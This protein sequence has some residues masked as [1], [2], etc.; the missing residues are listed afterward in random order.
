[1]NFGGRNVGVRSPTLF[2]APSSSQY[3]GRIAPTDSNSPLDPSPQA[4]RPNRTLGHLPGIDA[5]RAIAVMAVLAYH[6][7]LPGFRG[8]FLGVDAFFV[9]SGF[10]IS[11]LICLEMERTGTLD[12][13][14]FWI[15]RFKRLLPAMY[16]LLAVVLLVLAF[17]DHSKLISQR[18]DVA[19]AASYVTNWYQ[20]VANQSYFEAFGRPPLLRHL[21]SLAVEEQFYLV[22][23]LFFLALQKLRA[24]WWFSVGLAS[25]AAIELSGWMAVL[26]NHLG[27]FP[28]QEGI[29]KIYLRTDTR[30]P[31]LLV[32]V[33]LGVFFTRP[34]RATDSR[35]LT[36]PTRS[37]PY[38]ELS[39][40][41]IGI[42]LFALVA[43][44]NDVSPWL[45]RGGFLAFSVL[46]GLLVLL[47]S[48]PERKLLRKESYVHILPKSIQHWTPMQWVGKRS[49]SLYLWHWPIFVY[50]RPGEDLRLNRWIVEILRFGLSLLAAEASYRFIEGPFR[51]PAPF[52]QRYVFEGA[53]TFGTLALVLFGA[54]FLLKPQATELE[55][56][57]RANRALIGQGGQAQAET[58]A[59]QPPTTLV[60][61]PTTRA[62]PLSAPVFGATTTTPTTTIPPLG[63]SGTAIGDSVLLA[64]APAVQHRFGPSFVIDAT[65][66]RNYSKGLDVVRRRLRSGDLGDV[67]LLNLGTNGPAPMSQIEETL[68]DLSDVKVVVL[69]NVHLSGWKFVDGFNRDLAELATKRP[70]TVLADWNAV[71]RDHPF[72]FYKDKIH[73]KPQYAY[74]YSDL[75]GN[76]VE[77]ACGFSPKMLEESRAATTT[78]DVSDASNV[79]SVG[80]SDATSDGSTAP[81]AVDGAQTDGAQTDGVAGPSGP[82]PPR[83]NQQPDMVVLQ[84][85]GTTG[86]ARENL[87]P[88]TQHSLICSRTVSQR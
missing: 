65:T 10:L 36:H 73:V 7:D 67:V 82:T 37:F 75:V 85:S 49:Y 3:R 56:V 35:W 1:M 61:V 2:R 78:S 52:R 15:R 60:T 30:A 50:L 25:G 5:L 86:S 63:V 22:C 44:A 42:A 54:S 84:P 71:A 64:A 55:E 47:V 12:L 8:G 76:L 74:L 33:S 69:V 58:A 18:G 20:V 21:W 38:I 87:Q 29:S 16:A 26:Y 4:K 41:P 62:I 24:P 46:I 43:V 68:D 39:I 72:A 59:S 57:L 28:S 6:A 14:G 77:N 34:R 27:K 88:M 23:P 17:G 70:N 40:V 81:S 13:K 53:V 66:G 31:A 83:A 19:A 51:S 45:Y 80:P 48:W 32:G 11:A 79:E 9:I